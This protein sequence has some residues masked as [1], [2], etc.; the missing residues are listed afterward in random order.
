MVSVLSPQALGNGIPAGV[1]GSDRYAALYVRV[2]TGKQDENWSV[3][4]QRTLAKLGEQRG[5][6]VVEFYETV[7]GETIEARPKVRALLDDVQAGK[8]AAIICVDWNRLS[9]DE[10][11]IDGMIIKKACKDNDTLVI[12]PGKTYDFSTESDGMMAQFEMILAASYKQK[13]VKATTRARYEQ[14]RQTGYAGGVPEYGFQL[15]YD[16]PGRD[17]QMKARKVINPDQADVVRLIFDLYTNPANPLSLYAIARTL[18]ERGE[19]FPASPHAPK[20]RDGTKYA[21]GELRPWQAV[22][23]RRV[24]RARQYLGWFTY[25]ANKRNRYS[26]D[27]GVLEV[28]KPELQMVTY[29]LW[30]RA[31]EILKQRAGDPYKK[32]ACSPHALL[33]VLKC[34]KCDGAMCATQSPKG[35]CYRCYNE[36]TS[37]KTACEGQL[38]GV[39]GARRVVEAHLLAYIAQARTAIINEG[40]RQATTTSTID[41][42]RESAQAELAKAQENLETLMRSVAEKVFTLDE[43]RSLKLEYLQTIERVNG[44]LRKLE[45]AQEDTT[46][47]DRLREYLENL[48]GVLSGMNGAELRQL[49]RLVYHRIA[50]TPVTNPQPNGPRYFVDPRG[51]DYTPH[52]RELL[53]RFTSSTYVLR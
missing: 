29:D 20:R 28:H 30:Q 44:R 14:F 8:V 48:P 23:V 34:V 11:Y 40:I 4:D 36:R 26:R 39:K 10:D 53:E 13:L 24:L 19:R 27:L 31:Q 2:S 5:W 9:R 45:H 3:Q 18:N 37:G 42:L 49:L 47:T 7:S 43:A 33:G 32:S 6:R 25:G 52:A 51:F 21:A 17:G 38:I 35:D 16:V 15:V 22:D 46:K 12:T 1:G 50:L 41:Q